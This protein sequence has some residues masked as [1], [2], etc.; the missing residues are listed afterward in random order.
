MKRRVGGGITL[1]C[2][3]CD[4]ELDDTFDET[5]FHGMIDAAKAK[6]W[7]VR[8]DR[9]SGRWTHAC[10]SCKPSSVD[11]QRRLLGL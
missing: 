4:E 11:S 1:A 6:G 7:L 8:P 5:D 2:D 9:D 3:D 10:P